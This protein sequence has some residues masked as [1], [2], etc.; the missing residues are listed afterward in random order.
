[1]VR[2]RP[3][4]ARSFENALMRESITGDA[5]DGIGRNH[6]SFVGHSMLTSGFDGLRGLGYPVVTGYSF[7]VHVPYSLM[8]LVR[9]GGWCDKVTQ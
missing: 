1:M 7:C 2:E 5:V 4:S 6:D 8:F 9:G 3:L